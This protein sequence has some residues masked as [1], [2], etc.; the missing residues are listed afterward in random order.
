MNMEHFSVTVFC[1]GE[2]LQR[3]CTDVIYMERL[4]VSLV[5]FFAL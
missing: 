1:I 2:F 5:S 4:L 3:R